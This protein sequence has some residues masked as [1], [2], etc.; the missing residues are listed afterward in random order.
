MIG[1]LNHVAI[2]VR[3]VTKAAEVYRR[4]FGAQVSDPM[5]QPEHGNWR[6]RILSRS[7]TRWPA[8]SVTL[9]TRWRLSPSVRR[10]RCAPFIRPLLGPPVCDHSQKYPVGA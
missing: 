7:T 8:S 10:T 5:P 2:A 4:V 6:R 9:I 3:D 1:K